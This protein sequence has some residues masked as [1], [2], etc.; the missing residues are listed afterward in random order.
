M[1][2][3]LF[4][5]NICKELSKLHSGVT[6]HS[7]E[8]TQATLCHVLGENWEGVLDIQEDSMIGSGCVAQVYRGRIIEH[9]NPAADSMEPENTL[10]RGREVAVKILHPGI[11]ETMQVDLNLM[12]SIAQALEW[13]GQWV[14]WLFY[15]HTKNTGNSI[16]GSSSSSSSSGSSNLQSTILSP[17]TT[18][19]VA[20]Y[21]LRC[22]SLL[23]SVEE[24]AAFMQ[25]QLDLRAEAD[26]L[27][28][29]G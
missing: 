5:A 24:F 3:D 16:N 14:L 12:R 20:S 2:P 25:S 11:R 19:T 29:L 27:Q 9:K 28:R 1:R 8:Q 18:A 22:V 26:A 23:E 10:G 13:S 21:P 15:P 6:P 7:W 4:D 17:S